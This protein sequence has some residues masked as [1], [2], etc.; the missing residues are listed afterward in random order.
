M[1]EI[2]A[3]LSG[4]ASIRPANNIGSNV[5]RAAGANVIPKIVSIGGAIP[6]EESEQL[7]KAVKEHPK[8]GAWKDEIQWVSLQG[9]RLDKPSP[10]A[11]AGLVRKALKERGL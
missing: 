5:D 4:D 11:I 10:E 2:P 6:P 3:L 7:V 8:E 9:Q 1:Q